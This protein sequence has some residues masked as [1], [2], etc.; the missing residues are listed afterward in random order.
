MLF[1]VRR[2]SEVSDS[3][4]SAKAAV[5]D[6]VQNTVVIKDLLQLGECNALPLEVCKGLILARHFLR[7]GVVIPNSRT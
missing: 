2:A 7:P 3:S 5:K 1:V 4:L 6:T